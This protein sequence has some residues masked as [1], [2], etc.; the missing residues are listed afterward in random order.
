[1]I[2]TRHLRWGLILP[3]FAAVAL[4]GQLPHDGE[5][6]SLP[7]TTGAPLTIVPID[8][9]DIDCSIQEWNPTP[10]RPFV[11]LLC[12]PQSE[13]AQLRVYLKL[14]WM[15]RDDLPADLE[16]MR[17]PPGGFTKIRTNKNAVLVRLEVASEAGGRQHEQWVGFN[18]LSDLALIKD[19]R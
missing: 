2:R 17:L 1:M 10:P 18:A 9:Q 16:Q 12:P 3:V 11:K 7:R 6:Y 15:S 14:S 8:R 4:G 5:T 19:H 13:V